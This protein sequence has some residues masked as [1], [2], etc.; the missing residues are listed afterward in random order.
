MMDGYTQVYLFPSVILDM[1]YAV[2]NRKTQQK[3]YTPKRQQLPY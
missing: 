3:K 2:L 1:Y